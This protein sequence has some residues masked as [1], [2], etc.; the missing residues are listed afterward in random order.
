MAETIDDY[1]NWASGIAS[2]GVDVLL[3]E[4]PGYRTAPGTP[5]QKTIRTT[6]TSAYDWAKQAG[7]RPEDII[8]F[9]RS[10]G[11]AVALDLSEHREINQMILVSPF[12]SLADVLH[13]RRLPKALALGRFDNRSAIRDYTGN[14]LIIHGEQDQLLPF[15]MGQELLTAA[16]SPSTKKKILPLQA[17]HNDLIS[18]HQRTLTDQILRTATNKIP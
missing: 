2:R 4:Y 12:T 10:I 6:A 7:Y 18:R 8:I 13:L 15:T 5:N 17:G 3:V 11:A 9:G 1:A 16:G 14:L